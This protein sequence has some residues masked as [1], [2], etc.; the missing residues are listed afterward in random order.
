MARRK[1][2]PQLMT[3]RQWQEFQM[4]QQQQQR[5]IEPDYENM[6][7]PEFGARV[8]DSMGSCT[9]VAVGS[10]F[11]MANAFD[12]GDTIGGVKHAATAAAGISV[13]V[14]GLATIFGAAA[15]SRD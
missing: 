10:L 4:Q 7:L 8:Q 2:N 1:K 9:E 3:A 5:Q 13:L 6:P 15:G 14:Y 11:D 12:K